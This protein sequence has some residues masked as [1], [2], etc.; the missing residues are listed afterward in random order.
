MAC[1][2]LFV[3]HTLQDLL[4][5]AAPKEL[6]SQSVYISGIADLGP[7]FRLVQVP[8][9]GIPCFYCINCTTE[10]SLVYSLAERAVKP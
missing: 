2:K 5:R 9:D 8:V 7:F 6:F 1:V 10:L 3:S 4:C